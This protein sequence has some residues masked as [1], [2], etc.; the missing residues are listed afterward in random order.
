VPT[1]RLSLEDEQTARERLRPLTRAEAAALLDAIPRDGDRLLIRFLL[2]TGLRI[3]EA[4]GLT[5]KHVDLGAHPKV[6]VREQIYAGKRAALKTPSAI[7]DV[8]LGAYLADALRAQRRDA[9]AGP[10]AP[11][12]PSRVGTPRQASAVFGR[13]LK[14]AAR[15]I[16][17]PWAHLHTLRRTAGA[18]LLADGKT[19]VQV[20]AFLGHADPGWTLRSS[21]AGLVSADVGSVDLFDAALTRRATHQPQDDAGRTPEIPA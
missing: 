15:E 12:F 2:S 5:W 4:I 16:G 10:D 21:Y 9:Y 20:C 14:P 11:V 8:P 17:L 13:V 3:G 18:W 1:T 19:A 6:L 7:R